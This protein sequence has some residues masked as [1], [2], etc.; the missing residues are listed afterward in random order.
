MTTWICPANRSK[1]AWMHAGRIAFIPVAE[2]SSGRVLKRLRH[3]DREGW[4]LRLRVD[5][6]LDALKLRVFPV[7]V[8]V[9]RYKAPDPGVVVGSKENGIREADARAER[10]EAIGGACHIDARAT[11]LEPQLEPRCDVE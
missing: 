4:Y 1:V 3:F 7:A 10:H 6:H 2:A 8:D 5:E 9:K 11:F